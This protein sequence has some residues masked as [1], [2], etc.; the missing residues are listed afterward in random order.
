MGEPVH[1][2]Q[3]VKK[4]GVA[5]KAGNRTILQVSA[6]HLAAAEMQPFG[7]FAFAWITDNHES[8]TEKATAQALASLVEKLGSLMKG[9]GDIGSR[10]AGI[11]AMASSLPGGGEV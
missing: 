7:M 1:E 3:P 11:G 6:P 9:L 5:T 10:M 8:D 4:F 2:E